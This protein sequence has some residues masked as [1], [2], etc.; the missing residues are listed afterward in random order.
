MK[1]TEHGALKCLNVIDIGEG[2]VEMAAGEI[3]LQRGS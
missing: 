2:R 1:I 3:F